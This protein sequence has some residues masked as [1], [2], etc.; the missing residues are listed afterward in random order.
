M[1]SQSWTKRIEKFRATKTQVFW[2]CAACAVATIFV[3]FNWGGWVTGASA[4]EMT[5]KAAADARAE[6]A[7]AFCVHQF[8]S[9]P[10][11]TVQLATLKSTESWKRSEFIEKGGWVTL[12][13]TDELVAGAAALCA[14]QLTDAQAPA[15][16][17]V[18]TS[19]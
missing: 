7:S 5:V 17:A 10:K 13:G 9:D 11:A 14:K 8:A 3:G 18:G 1:D 4:R 6:L 19:G 12:P 2:A 15:A 16:S